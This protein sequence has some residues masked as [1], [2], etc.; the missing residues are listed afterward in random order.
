MSG[1]ESAG[2][3]RAPVVGMVGAGQLA[4]MTHQA[5]VDLGVDLVVLAKSPEDPAV[6]AGARALYG[7]ADD[8]EA[9]ARLAGLAD[10]VTFDHEQVPNDLVVS[11]EESGVA[12]AP[13]SRALNAAQDK[14]AARRLFSA[15]GLD[16]PAFAEVGPDAGSDIVSFAASHG[17]PVVLKARTGG[18]DGRGVAFVAGPSGV[19]AALSSLRGA[20]LLV[21]A[22]VL[23]A[24]EVAVLAARSTIGEYAAY[25]TVATLQEDGICTQLSMPASLDPEVESRAHDLAR[26]VAELVGATGIIAVE[27]FVEPSGRVLINEIAVRPHNSGHATIE[28]CVTSQFHNHLRAVLGWPLG[29]TSLVKG[30]AAM[31]NVLGGA[32]GIDPRS[33][34]VDALAVRGASVHLYA[35]AALPGRKVGH[36]TALGDDPSEA[37]ATARRCASIL[38][39]A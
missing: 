23:L 38:G 1:A 31:V 25:P 26:S 18:Y 3:F 8:P 11:L 32:D 37:V 6:L 35:K 16:V 29:D 14:L 27:L 30:A 7:R 9:L 15:A 13:G 5:S 12:V 28:G 20:D 22:H 34:L 39:G 19:D 10:V 21:E 2:A 17:W 36:V 24:C 4:R 33:R